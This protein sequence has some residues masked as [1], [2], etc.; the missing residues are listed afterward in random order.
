MKCCLALA[1]F[2]VS[3]V[4]CGKETELN[5]ARQA[6]Y[7]CATDCTCQAGEPRPITTGDPNEAAFCTNCCTC[8]GPVP[9]FPSCQ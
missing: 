2:V 6:L 7:T 9:V 8:P 4:G 5:Q 1:L 3:I